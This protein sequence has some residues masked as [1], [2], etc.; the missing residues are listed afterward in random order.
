V[1][2]PRA[3]RLHTL[4]YGKARPVGSY[5]VSQNYGPDP[6]FVWPEP[7][8]QHD[9]SLRYLSRLQFFR[10]VTAAENQTGGCS[11]T[12]FP[13]ASV[14]SGIGRYICVLCLWWTST[15]VFGSVLK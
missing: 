12:P 5:K 4:L 10:A 1:D 11:F 2:R 7:V 3:D 9:G 14:L 13:S 6:R 8:R 15:C